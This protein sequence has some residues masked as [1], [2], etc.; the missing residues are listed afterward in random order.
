M[1][2]TTSAC[3][4]FGS[5][6]AWHR[7]R[8]SHRHRKRMLHAIPKRCSR[9]EGRMRRR[10]FRRMTWTTRGFRTK[11]RQYLQ[12]RHGETGP[13]LARP[14]QGLDHTHSK[15]QFWW[16]ELTKPS[17]RK[18]KGAKG[19]PSYANLRREFGIDDEH[20]DPLATKYDDDSECETVVSTLEPVVQKT[21]TV[22]L[23]DFLAAHPMVNQ[24]HLTVLRRVFAAESMHDRSQ[25]QLRVGRHGLSQPTSLAVA[26]LWHTTLTL[27]TLEHLAPFSFFNSTHHNRFSEFFLARRFVTVVD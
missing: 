6:A 4:L 26:P 19:A 11:V 5:F 14:F 10:H 15:K 1:H 3:M 12:R 9:N 18:Q 22:P 17:K 13:D 21:K 27:C 8:N 7:K 24:K 16:I 20:G 2:H 23:K 25:Q